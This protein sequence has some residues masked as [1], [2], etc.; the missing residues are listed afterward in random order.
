[1]S[2]DD[3]L[4]RCAEKFASGAHPLIF[5]PSV[6]G[7]IQ[8]EV[9]E[10]NVGEVL[11]GNSQLDMRGEHVALSFRKSVR[12]TMIGV[13]GTG[14]TV[15]LNNIGFQTARGGLKTFFLNDMKGNLYDNFCKPL[16]QEFRYRLPADSPSFNFAEISR[17]FYEV[18]VRSIH[19]DAGLTVEL[20]DAHPDD[21]PFF[22]G[23]GGFSKRFLYQFVKHRSFLHDP[24][25][26]IER[27]SPKMLRETGLNVVPKDKRNAILTIADELTAKGVIGHNDR[28]FSSLI[29]EFSLFIFNTRGADV[30]LS[31]LDIILSY[32]LRKISD[33]SDPSLVIFD[34]AHRL[35]G[36]K[37]AITNTARLVRTYIQTRREASK[38]MIFSGQTVRGDS[39]VDPKIVAICDYLL[40][41]GNLP[42]KDLRIVTE[43]MGMDVPN[44]YLLRR[45][46]KGK[47]WCI[48]NRHSQ[49]LRFFWTYASPC[50]IAT[51]KT[52]G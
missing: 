45:E 41:G 19:L 3:F 7:L 16:Q 4:E 27:L 22:F 17:D 24:V 40:L 44:Y 23:M 46:L 18:L 21:I 9:R 30:E 20:A 38:S 52:L 11:L 43:A 28:P 10:Y 14:K 2:Q 34:E 33:S 32:A 39:A 8:E 49:E 31:S 37:R 35:L 26:F 13:P 15:C 51:E 25:G 12:A 1:M 42:D 29:D 47:K 36:H 5:L 6:Q 48:Y 50:R